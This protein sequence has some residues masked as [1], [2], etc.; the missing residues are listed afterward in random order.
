M[1]FLCPECGNKLKAPAEHA[2]RTA[3][4][5]R[6]G[7]PLVVPGAVTT[8]ATAAIPSP[9]AQ[10]PMV[11][12]APNVVNSAPFDDELPIQFPRLKQTENAD[13]DL[14]PMIDVVFQ[15]LIF[16][17][18]TASF[19]LQK[20]LDLPAGEASE[21]SQ[22]ARTVE[23]LEQDEDYVIVRVEQDNTIWVNDAEAISEPDLFA[24]LRAAKQ[25][26]SG[27]PGAKRLLV[28]AHGGAKHERVVMTLDAGST[29]G[30]ES[31]KL[32]TIDDP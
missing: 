20:S 23:E 12:A 14:T 8:V 4:C 32:A 9:I 3:R 10:P 7:T 18:V 16:F 5:T 19:G 1:Q 24:K 11:A 26:R 22:A 28:V 13:I 6:C 25:P 27:E 2:G 30:M 29:A 15:L 17:M 31:V 21:E